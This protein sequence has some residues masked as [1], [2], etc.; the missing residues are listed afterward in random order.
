LTK[1]KIKIQ[2]LGLKNFLALSSSRF[3]SVSQLDTVLLKKPPLLTNTCD[4]VLVADTLTSALEVLS[5]QDAGKSTNPKANECKF[6]FYFSVLSTSLPTSLRA[7]F[8]LCTTSPSNDDLT[9]VASVQNNICNKTITLIT[10]T[11][12]HE[13]T[14]PAVSLITNSSSF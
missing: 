8:E 5:F 2:Q 6:Y 14:A 11:I 12:T 10:Q 9:P 4:T 7:F 1:K 3:L 13:S